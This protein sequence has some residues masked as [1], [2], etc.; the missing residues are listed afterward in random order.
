MN[1]KCPT[2]G[3]NG[4]YDNTGL[5]DMDRLGVHI[6]YPEDVRVAEY[7]GTTVVQMGEPVNLVSAWQA[8]GANMNY[9]AS[10]FQWTVNG[11]IRSTSPVLNLVLPAGANP[12]TLT[13]QDLLGRTYSYSGTI[14]VLGPADYDNSAAETG[15]ANSSLL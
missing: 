10:G 6:L 4:N 3:I 7:V 1:Y 9:V 2:G 13:H 8:R 12:F 11:S 15:A 14:T 5:S